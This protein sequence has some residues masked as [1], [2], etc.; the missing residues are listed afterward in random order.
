MNH[1]KIILAILQIT[2]HGFSSMHVPISLSTPVTK[3][4]HVHR[5]FSVDDSNSRTK[6]GAANILAT[7]TINYNLPPASFN[8][9]TLGVRGYI[10]SAWQY[11]DTADFG[12]R[13]L[14]K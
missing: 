2:T 9:D 3:E 12:P 14:R 11:T 8:S 1:K 4:R 5:S 10:S 6:E 7:S 13:D